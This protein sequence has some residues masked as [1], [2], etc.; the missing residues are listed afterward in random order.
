MLQPILFFDGKC[1]LCNKTVR[2]IIN[3]EASTTYPILF[4]SLQSAYAKQALAK[5]H[6]NFNQLSTLV[7][8]TDESVFYTSD[9]VL[10]ICS[11]LKVPYA[12]VTVFKIVPVFIRDGIYNY[13]ANNRQH[14][15]K[16]PFCYKPSSTLKSRFIE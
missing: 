6:Y 4:C 14:L 5:Y 13:I 12:W 9:A 16:A 15:S 3:H 7:L 2:F 10:K 8:I 1:S 11:Y